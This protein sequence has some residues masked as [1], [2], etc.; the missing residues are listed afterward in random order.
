M[1]VAFKVS[2]AWPK[3]TLPG[4]LPRYPCTQSLFPSPSASCLWASLL[5]RAPPP[6]LP[7]LACLLPC[8]AL[9]RSF[10]AWE[11]SESPLF[12]DLYSISETIIIRLLQRPGVSKLQSV[13][14]VW[15]PSVFV[16][17]VLFEHSYSPL[18][19]AVYTLQQQ[20]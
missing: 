17:K 2:L 10:H 13:G 5:S 3:L 9:C 8:L 7:L 14:Q 16:N 18:S 20:S 6:D 19:M 11:G 4:P 15:P 12:S 1:C